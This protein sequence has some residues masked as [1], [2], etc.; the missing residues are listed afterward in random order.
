MSEESNSKRPTVPVPG[1]GVVDGTEL[2]GCKAAFRADADLTVGGRCDTT[3]EV[4]LAAAEA[5]TNGKYTG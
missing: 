1:V 5:K 2:E 3:V 4:A